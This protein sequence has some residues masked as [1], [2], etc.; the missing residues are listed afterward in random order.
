[1]KI[2][3]MNSLLKKIPQQVLLILLFGNIACTEKNTGSDVELLNSE[4]DSLTRVL[5]KERTFSD[6]LQNILQVKRSS[7]SDHPVSLDRKFQGIENPEKYII[8]TLKKSPDQIPMKGIHGGNMQFRK[9]TILTENWLLAVYDDG[10]IQGKSIY[11][12]QL[13]PND[14]LRFSVIASENMK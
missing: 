1:M 12:F 13:L 6:S 4:V 5:E 3:M 10:H 7:D 11:E 2:F 9:I 14:S 8:N